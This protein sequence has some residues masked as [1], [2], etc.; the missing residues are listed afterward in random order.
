MRDQFMNVIPETLATGVSKRNLIKNIKD[1]YAAKGTSEGHKLFFKTFLGE[2]PEIFYPTEFVMR[3][4]D[5]NWGQKTTIRVT[6]A[7]NVSGDEVINQVITG[8]SSDATA[9]V[10]SS[11]SFTQG[12]FAVTELELQNIVGTFTDGEIIK[13]VSSTRDVEVSF[14][15]SSQITRHSSKRW[16]TKQYI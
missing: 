6:A 14:T 4:S 5:G 13:A 1:L 3:S 7:A 9:V 11:T 15:V 2:E 16:N 8:Q 10:V 12:Q